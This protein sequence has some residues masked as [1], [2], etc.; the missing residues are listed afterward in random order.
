[1]NQYNK[2]YRI[3]QFLWKVGKWIFV[4][5]SSICKYHLPPFLWNYP[6]DICNKMLV[7]YI[8][9]SFQLYFVA[10]RDYL[11]IYSCIVT[12]FRWVVLSVFWKCYVGL[13]N[14]LDSCKTQKLK[15]FLL[16]QARKY[17]SRRWI[18]LSRRQYHCAKGSK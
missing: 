14:Y 13:S 15:Y 2:K 8:T 3:V 18:I 16:L 6:S 12:S 7:T 9:Y 11:R 5:A 1:M 4:S 17:N 10:M